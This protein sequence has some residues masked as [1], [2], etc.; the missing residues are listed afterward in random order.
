MTRQKHPGDHLRRKSQETDKD[1]GLAAGRARLHCQ[2]IDANDLLDKIARLDGW[3]Q[4]PRNP[5]PANRT[6]VEGGAK[7]REI[8]IGCGIFRKRWQCVTAELQLPQRRSR[9][10]VRSATG[11]LLNLDDVSE[12]FA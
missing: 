11:V 12:G 2:I 6:I 7:W 4:S 1:L 8:E 3:Q 9:L 10:A 5:A